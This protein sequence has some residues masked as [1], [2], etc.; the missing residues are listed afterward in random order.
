MPPIELRLNWNHITLQSHH[1]ITYQQLNHSILEP[2]F[3]AL[4]RKIRAKS[5]VKYAPDYS[6][7]E[8]LFNS[9]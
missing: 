9:G 5:S 3:T 4:L 7:A 8:L 2:L 6:R 1:S